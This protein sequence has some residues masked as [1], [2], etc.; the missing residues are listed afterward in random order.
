VASPE[1]DYPA[2]DEPGLRRFFR[3]AVAGRTDLESVDALTALGEFVGPIRMGWLDEIVPN[4]WALADEIGIPL[5][6]SGETN[7]AEGTA[8]SPVGSVKVEA[9]S[10][11]TDHPFVCEGRVAVRLR[12]LNEKGVVVDETLDWE[13][14]SAMRMSRSSR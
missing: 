11:L 4:R 5:E 14:Y 12:L 3:F 10:G 1:L 6:Y 13:G 8:F 9:L 7:P 2:F